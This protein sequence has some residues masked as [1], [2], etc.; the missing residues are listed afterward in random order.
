MLAVKKVNADKVKALNRLLVVEFSLAFLVTLFTFLYNNVNQNQSDRIEK[1]THNTKRQIDV[2]DTKAD[3]SIKKLD[4]LQVENI[5]LQDKVIAMQNSQ[6]KKNKEL[7]ELSEKLK[8]ATIENQKSLQENLSV[9]KRQL[10]PIPEEFNI[11]LMLEIKF[12]PEFEEKILK[13]IRREGINTTMT[14]SGTYGQINDSILEDIFPGK[15]YWLNVWFCK[16]FK[17]DS[18]R[19]S[20]NHNNI[21]YSNFTLNYSTSL[22]GKIVPMYDSRSNLFLLMFEKIKLLRNQYNFTSNLATKGI[23]NSIFDLDSTTMILFIP[24][25]EDGASFKVSNIKVE[26]KELNLTFQDPAS[27]KNKTAI[28]A[29]R[30]EVK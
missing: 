29:G 3:N 1:N 25:L 20:S 6:I 13:K 9:S 23:M 28:V 2:L 24:Q 4:S 27:T 15:M 22:A 5:S 26:S 18:N 17:V 21:Q 19:V 16:E 12:K 8:L 7:I 30:V 14:T 11:S 10:F